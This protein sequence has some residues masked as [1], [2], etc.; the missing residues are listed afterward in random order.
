MAKP[1]HN[2][3]DPAGG[4]VGQ[5]PY[6]LQVR[7]LFFLVF[8][9]SFLELGKLGDCGDSLCSM[10]RSS[11]CFR[12]LLGNWGEKVPSSNKKLWNSY[13]LSLY[14]NPIYAK[15][16]SL[17]CLEQLW[18]HRCPLHNLL[19]R[20]GLWVCKFRE[21]RDC[22][23]ATNLKEVAVAF[24]GLLNQ[25]SAESLASYTLKD[26]NGFVQALKSVALQA[27]KKSVIITV[28]TS[29][30][31]QE[32]YK[33]SV[34]SVKGSDTAVAAVN[35]TDVSFTPVDAA[36]PTIEKIEGLGNKAIK[37][38][39]SEPVNS[40]STVADTFK[41]D[42]T[43]VSGI[44]SGSGTRTL[45][46]ELFSPLAVGEHTLAI[47]NKI[48]DFAVYNL[49]ATSQ[50]FTV[51]EDKTAPTVVEV[52]DVTLEGATVVFS[53][54]VKDAEATTGSNYYW[55]NGTTKNTAD[56]TVTR[57][58]GKTFKITFSGTAKLPAVATD[59][60]ITNIVDYT[61]NVI[62]ANWKVS[63]TPIVDQTRPEVV[64]A[65]Y[66][67]AS[68]L[69]L[70]FS[71]A[72]D[73]ST[74]KTS[75]VVVK[76]SKGVVVSK[77]VT[78]AEGYTAASQIVTLN[79]T[80]TFDAGT[81]T[82]EVSGLKDITTLANSMLP[83]TT[84]I[85][86]KD[87]A[88][89]NVSAVTGS[90]NVYYV[91]FDK[92]MDASILNPDSYY[93]T[94]Y[95]QSSTNKAG[96]LPSGTNIVPVNGNKGV[97]ITL[98]STVTS[99]AAITVQGV[100]SASGVVLSGYVQT[101]IITN[102]FAARF[103]YA[104]ATDSAMVKFN[105]PVSRLANLPGITVNS[106]QVTNATVDPTDST[107][108]K[109]TAANTTTDASEAIVVPANAFYN[110]NGA[111]NNL[112]TGSFVGDAIA[113]TAKKTAGKIVVGTGITGTNTQTITVVFDEAV[114]VKNVAKLFENF[115]AYKADGTALTYGADF[116]VTNAGTAAGQLAHAAGTTTAVLSFAGTSYQ[117][118]VNIAFNNGNG[119]VVDVSAIDTNNIA[120]TDLA[121]VGFDTRDASTVTG[122]IL[123][124]D[125]FA[126][127][128]SS[129]AFVNGTGTAAT[130]DAGD[131]IVITYNEAVIV[132][133]HV[134]GAAASASS[135][136]LGD[137]S[138]AGT[139]AGVGTFVTVGGIT[140]GTT[141]NTVAL[142]A[143][144]KTLTITLG[145]VTGTVIPSGDFTPS[146]TPVTDVVG[147]AASTA[148]LTAPATGSF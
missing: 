143:D 27:D 96:K 62:A 7:R 146:A 48:V 69:K 36:L 93:L 68:Q 28:N 34:N 23:S 124:P 50:K 77:G 70:T 130:A 121:A 45:I 84:T 32:V 136:T 25:K 33:L 75:N 140:T 127:T 46:V 105:Q 83:Y 12:E 110:L 97:I 11:F 2:P 82:I 56:A 111:F 67:D 139:I 109:L 49:I 103:A 126:A 6:L 138:A 148:V 60:Y 73:L 72:V 102:S 17:F 65:I 91:T 137:T 9:T 14:W 117:G 114:K 57:I 122:T 107:L 98:P 123:L 29:L 63:I 106:V 135:A 120:K 88:A 58:D 125:L 8:F 104:T 144:G 18:E 71:K 16:F 47:N 42:E 64:N 21:K 132:A 54:D 37:I 76:D 44:L 133:G 26:A 145:A 112:Y 108:V 22:F 128:I 66:D 61:G 51:V 20:L 79:F 129:I 118:Q 113:P 147:N 80:G 74:F 19:S 119:N 87:Q 52:K 55:L 59:L 31:N 94:A 13:L 99:V 90:A 38:T 10:G 134:A 141:T 3:E 40:I 39:F 53:E 81:Y 100:K 86:A 78:V 24:D 89:P 35:A 115:A 4:E 95:I 142:S 5:Y 43:V 85:G 15:T 30:N 1:N 92:A 101:P 41:I 131:K 116:L